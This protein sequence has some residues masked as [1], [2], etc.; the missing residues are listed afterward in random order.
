MASLPVRHS[1]ARAFASTILRP[2]GQR[3]QELLSQLLIR[4][5]V[6]ADLEDRTVRI[7]E[8]LGELRAAN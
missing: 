7:D 2:V 4:L 1:F 8:L 3:L 6:E 5:A